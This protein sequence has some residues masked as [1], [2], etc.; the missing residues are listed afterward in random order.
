MKKIL[1]PIDFSDATI[2]VVN[3]SKKFAKSFGG[4]IRLLHVAAPE[5][6]F[7]GNDVGPKVIR[8]QKAKKLREEHRKIQE[9]GKEL[10]NEGIKTTP[11]MVQGVT[12]DEIINEAEKFNADVIIMGSHGPSAVY[13]ILMGSVI[14]GVIRK[15]DIPIL[16]V[17]VKE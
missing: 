2:K 8:E 7:V 17:P 10:E 3:E 5:P 6:S 1:V 16:L 13:N 9:I 12:V 15:T 14:E 4:E 11:L